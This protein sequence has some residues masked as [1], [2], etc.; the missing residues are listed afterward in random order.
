MYA[1]CS[2]DEGMDSG[3]FSPRFHSQQTIVI[4]AF[5]MVRRGK[6]RYLVVLWVLIGVGGV[7][8]NSG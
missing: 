3:V 7:Y 5:C 4:E 8:L 1:I 2:V 6:G